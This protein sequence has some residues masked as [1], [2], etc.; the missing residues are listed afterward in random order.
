MAG[1]HIGDVWIPG[2]LV[3]GPM[4]GVTDLPFRLLC[5]EQGADL[6]YTEMISAEGIYY[7]NKNTKQLWT[8][9][10]Q[11]HPVALQLFGSEPELMGEIAAQIQELPFDILDINMGCPVPKVVS[12]GEGSALMKHPKLAAEIVS[13]VSRSISKPV[14]VKFRKGFAERESSAVEF[15]KEMEAAGASAIAVHGRTREQYYGGKADWAVIAKVKEAVKIPV[16]ASG[17]IFT[18][19]DAARCQTETG[20]DGLMLARGVR[21]NPWLFHQ[22]KTYL[23]TG[24]K[25]PVPSVAELVDMILRHGSMLMEFKGEYMAMRE[26]RKHVAW[27]TAGYPGSAALRRRVNEIETYHDLEKLLSENVFT[28]NS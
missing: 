7:K 25:E 15:A 12:N 13:S 26:M 1:F 27:Y 4:A 20:C 5:K 17:D 8:I 18:P 14:T 22:T 16:I 3:L 9:G 2:S 23:E 6:V 21:G 10:E 19:E 28:K 11:E 24:E